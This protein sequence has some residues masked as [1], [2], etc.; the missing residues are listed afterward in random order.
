MTR[1]LLSETCCV[2][3]AVPLPCKWLT[4]DGHCAAGKPPVYVG[5]GSLVV[6]D[7]QGLTLMILS[8]AKRTHQRI[9]LSRCPQTRTNEPTSCTRESK[10]R[11][12]SWLHSSCKRAE[13]LQSLDF[14]ATDG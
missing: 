1:N 8:A 2:P 3:L 4:S 12:V 10:P 6:D 9:L 7:P 13:S 14:G 11:E 5:F